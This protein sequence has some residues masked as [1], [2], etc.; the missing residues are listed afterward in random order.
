M[1]RRRPL[2][3]AAAIVSATMVATLSPGTALS[4]PQAG[5]WGPAVTVARADA[6][7][8]DLELTARR[9]LQVAAWVRARGERSRVVVAVKVR[10]GAWGSPTRVPGTRGATEVEVGLD[11][12]GRLVAAWT[13]GRAVKSAALRAGGWSRPV[14]LHRTRAGVRGVFPGYLDLAVNRAGRAVLAWETVDDD[15]DGV[16]ARPRVQ[17]TVRRP[18]GGWARTRTLSTGRGAALR[19]EAALDDRGRATVVWSQGA[20]ARARVMTTSR[21]A[22][23]PW[24][25]GRALSRLARTGTP[26]LAALPGGRLAVAWDF[27]GVGAAGI[28]VRRWARGNGWGTPEVLR[29]PRSVGWLEAAIDRRG[30]V[31]AAWAGRRGALRTATVDASGRWTRERVAPRGSVFSDLELAVNRSGDGLLAW[32]SLDGGAHPLQVAYRRSGAGWSGVRNLTV[33]GDAWGRAATLAPRGRATVVWSQGPAAESV[34]RVRARS[35]VPR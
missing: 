7:V 32:V 25:E 34:R 30:R 23:D 6:D 2:L 28:V 26:R 3:P 20:G 9:G 29:G 12:R 5:D 24:D 15:R 1:P 8:F 4:A 16:Q 31:T 14:V 19:P 10:G 18:A 27:S 35:Y 21:P 13:S 22:G 17:A 11:G 33:R